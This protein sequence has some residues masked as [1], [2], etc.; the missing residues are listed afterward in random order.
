MAEFVCRSTFHKQANIAK[1]LKEEVN[2]EYG[3]STAD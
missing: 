1:S 2:M 3:P